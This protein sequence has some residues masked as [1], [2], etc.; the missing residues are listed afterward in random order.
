MKRLPLCTVLG[1]I[2]LFLCASCASVSVSD[3]KAPDRVPPLRKPERIFVRPYELGDESLRVDRSGE[4]LREFETRFQAQLQRDLV[5]ALSRH[6]APAEAVD[7]E[8]ALP[9][10]DYWEVSGSFLRVE[11]GSRLMRSVIGYGAGA[12]RMDLRHTISSLESRPPRELLAI[13]TTGGSNAQPGAINT[14]LYFFTGVG[15]LLAIVNLQNGLWTGLSFD[16]AR[17]A[18]EVASVATEELYE[19]GEIPRRRVEPAKYAGKI[20]RDWWRPRIPLPGQE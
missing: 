18:H 12:T 9:A 14:G 8:E 19:R 16:S 5:R 4:R 6:V 1:T 7:Q 15:G 2:L 13:T 20:P 10:G 17:S 3:V 11:Q